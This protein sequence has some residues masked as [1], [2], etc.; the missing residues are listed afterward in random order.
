MRN[1]SILGES[2]SISTEMENECYLRRKIDSTIESVPSAFEK[3]W[4]GL[5]DCED[6]LKKFDKLAST[7]FS[8]ILQCSIEI[9]QEQ[10]IYNLDSELFINKY[11]SNYIEETIQILEEV[12]QTLHRI[13]DQYKQ[14]VAYRELQ[15]R[16][17]SRV[18]GGG[19]GLGGALK[20]MATAAALNA[21]S[22]MAHSLGNSIGNAGSNFT[23][24]NS[25][26]KLFKSAKEPLK[27]AVID[28][29]FLLRQGLRNALLSEAGIECIPVSSDDAKQATVLVQNFFNNSIPEEEKKSMLI[30]ALILNPYKD[31]VYHLIWEKYGDPN[32]ELREMADF[33]SCDLTHKIQDEAISYGKDVLN[34]LCAP[35]LT[36]FNK[37]SIA[38]RYNNQLEEAKTLLEEYR[39]SHNLKKESMPQLIFCNELLE[40][41]DL[42]ARTVNG[43]IY[44]SE[45]IARKYIHDYMLL[46]KTLIENEERQEDLD[47]VMKSLPFET[48]D[49]K[50]NYSQYIDEEKKSRNANYIFLNIKK[51]FENLSLSEE[52]D[53]LRFYIPTI[54]ND[55]SQIEMMV[56]KLSKMHES[57]VPLLL[58]TLSENANIGLLI[59][60][61]T[62]RNYSGIPLLGYCNAYTLDGISSISCYDD[63][64]FHLVYM[65]NKIKS[66]NFG[67]KK[68]NSKIQILLGDL[69][70]QIH[71]LIE[72]LPKNEK[73]R[74]YRIYNGVA[75]CSC[76]TPLLQGETICPHCKK[77]RKENGEFVDSMKCP[78]CQNIVP[79]TSKFC[80]YCGEKIEC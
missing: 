8:P 41:V 40:M 44:P 37:K 23:A 57:E 47:V 62:I 69:F 9:L 27:D 52:T 12:H 66:I 10:K 14:E 25:K 7:I 79:V 49:F 38:L 1:Y 3:W 31:D 29:A 24:S 32:F 51:I 36:A 30:K 2:L 17:R 4:N 64:V 55:F 13:D 78:H 71:E 15:K 68:I 72:R 67:K 74:L 77:I 6:I 59:T 33:F 42:D 63:G 60:D 26:D 58:C 11:A 56:K 21:T 45:E 43:K 18:V 46:S 19:F 28:G 39:S 35:C 48:E 50:K 76:G 75:V 54:M 53:D 80:R 20:G 73:Q 22:G 61:K 5:W 70:S 65:N 16:Y 34:K